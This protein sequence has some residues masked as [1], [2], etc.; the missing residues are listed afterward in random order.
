MLASHRHSIILV[1]S[2]DEFLDHFGGSG[3][4]NMVVRS[5]EELPK[6]TSIKGVVIAAELATEGFHAKIII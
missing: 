6:N 2:N 4:V 5:V 3:I 1:S